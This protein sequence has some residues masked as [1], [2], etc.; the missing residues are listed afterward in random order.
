[1][2]KLSKSGS[3]ILYAFLC[4]CSFQAWSQQSCYNVVG[5]LPSWSGVPSSVDYSKY[6][7]IN[8]SFGIPNTNGTMAPIENTAKL[9]DLVSRGHATNTKVLLAVGGWLSS[10]PASTPFESIAANSS[11]VTTFVNTCANLVT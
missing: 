6:T 5:Y 3:L 4:L 7:H 8:Y 1:M 11:Y 2:K 10:S 9:S